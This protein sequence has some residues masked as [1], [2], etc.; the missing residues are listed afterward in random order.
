MTSIATMLGFRSKLVN[1]CPK[2]YVFKGCYYSWVA[3]YFRYSNLV[4]AFLID[5]V[6]K[7]A[8]WGVLHP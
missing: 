4:G 8:N 7:I 3:N 6:G 5:L 1:S 2:M